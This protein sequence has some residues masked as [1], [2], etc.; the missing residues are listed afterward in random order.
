MGP[1]I[2]FPLAL[3]HLIPIMKNVRYEERRREGR[4]KEAVAKQIE[5]SK[6]VTF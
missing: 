4:E 2:A 3:L 5:S 1:F 6:V